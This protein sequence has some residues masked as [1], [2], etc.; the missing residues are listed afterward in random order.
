MTRSMDDVNHRDHLV[1][2]SSTVR[3]VPSAKPAGDSSAIAA[4]TNA[5]VVP[6]QRAKGLR[7]RPSTIAIACQQIITARGISPSHMLRTMTQGCATVSGRSQ[8]LDCEGLSEILCE[9]RDLSVRG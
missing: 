5:V 6:I 8:P 7:S 1:A 4:S 3:R 9:W 2:V